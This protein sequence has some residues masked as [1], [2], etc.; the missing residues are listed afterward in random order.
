MTFLR[1]AE[2]VLCEYL[3]GRGMKK[4]SSKS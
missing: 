4:Q 1:E 3:D 2:C